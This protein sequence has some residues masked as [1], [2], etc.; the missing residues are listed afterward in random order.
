MRIQQV[1]F[2][3]KKIWDGMK[4]SEMHKKSENGKKN[5]RGPLPRTDRQTTGWTTLQSDK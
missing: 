4:H 3:V 2:W 1:Q 5:L